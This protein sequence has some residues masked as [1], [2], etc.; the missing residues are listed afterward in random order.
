[1]DT[2]DAKDWLKSKVKAGGI[3]NPERAVKA[4][5]LSTQMSLSDAIHQ[6]NASVEDVQ[7]VVP[8][9]PLDDSMLMPVPLPSTI[10]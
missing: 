6:A 8:A 3:V 2:V 1:M 9:G 10:K 5:S 7:R 4:A